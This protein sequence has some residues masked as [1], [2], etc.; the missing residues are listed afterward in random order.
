MT[1]QTELPIGI[2]DGMP[3][4]DMA[5]IPG[6]TF[7]MGSTAFYP[8]EAPSEAEW[9]L[10]ARGGIEGAVYSWG[11]EFMPGGRVM[12][13]TWHGD[14]PW[15][16]ARVGRHPKTMPVGSFALNGYGLYGMA[17]NVWEWTSDWYRPRHAGNAPKACCTPNNPRGGSM[18]QSYDPMQPGCTFRARC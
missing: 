10:A 12:A 2:A 11:D 14:F 3:Q 13:N 8:N 1:I 17:G 18:K 15:Q 4:A 6:G 5:W 9:E 7:Q 16:N